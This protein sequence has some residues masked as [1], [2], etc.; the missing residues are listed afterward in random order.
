MYLRRDFQEKGAGTRWCQVP[1][2]LGFELP[3]SGSP[4]RG[5]LSF[6]LPP[7]HL[8]APVGVLA[9]QQGG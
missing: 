6:P 2:P 9:N 7:P 5:I 8:S 1:T 4:R 3:R